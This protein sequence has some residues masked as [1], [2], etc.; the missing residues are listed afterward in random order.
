[1]RTANEIAVASAVLVLA[2]RAAAAGE[3]DTGAE[4]SDAAHA[5]GA[6]HTAD[7][8]GRSLSRRWRARAPLAASKVS[9][10]S[11]RL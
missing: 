6:E 5:S 1:M 10:G 4:A 11:S 2:D 7:L 8:A 9:N 3:S